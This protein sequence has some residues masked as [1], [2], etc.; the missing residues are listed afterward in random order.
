MTM[1]PIY[2]SR[3]QDQDFQKAFAEALEHPETS[4]LV[5][6]LSGMGGIGKTAL[7]KNLEETHK[8]D[9][10]FVKVSFD[11]NYG[12]DN[13]IKLMAALYDQVSD[14]LSVF[15][16]DIFAWHDPFS[17]LHEKY[18]AT[19]RRLKTEP[20][21]G[22]QSV[23]EG[24]LTKVKALLSM[25][26]GVVGQLIW[27]GIGGSTMK[28][29]TEAVVDGSVMVLTEK[30]RLE[31]LNQH[32]A[33]K[34]KKAVQD[35]MLEPLPKLTR[36]FVEG[37]IQWARRQP[38][39]LLLDTYEKVSTDIDTWLW[40]HL[41][42]NTDLQSH[43][44]RLVIA[45]RWP[46]WVREHW[47]KI[48]Q[49]RKI[50]YHQELI[51]FDQS[52]AKEY[53]KSIEKTPEQLQQIYDITKGWPYFLNWIREQGSSFDLSQGHQKFARFLLQGYSKEHQQFVYSLACCRTFDRKVAQFI[54]KHQGTDAQ[55]K[56]DTPLN[57]FEWLKQQSFV[58]FAEGAYRLDDV[59]RDVFRR[60][61]WQEDRE[62]FQQ[63]HA[64]LA[65]YFKE[66]ADQIVSSERPVLDGYNDPDWRQYMATY[67]Y[68]ALCS[69]Q[70]DALR[71]FI[72]H[73]FISSYVSQE[74]VV[75]KPFDSLLAEI[76]VADQPFLSE[77]LREFLT[78]I[79]PVV[80]YSIIF[81]LNVVHKKLRLL[82]QQFLEV[83]KFSDSEIQN[84]MQR[85]LRWIDS[86]E[87]LAKFVGLLYKSRHVLPIQQAEWCQKAYTQAEHIATTFTPEFGSRLFVEVGNEWWM[88]NQYA[89]AIAAYQKAIE[90]KPDA[91]EAWYNLGCV[92]ALQKDVKR[93]V[94][95]LGQAIQLDPE[96]RN[97]ACIDPDFDGIRDD[98]L[99]QSLLASE[100]QGSQ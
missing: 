41:I 28:K 83:I 92:Y 27:P 60:V 45:G 40:Y 64:Q 4:P 46:L 80:E 32:R 84:A 100:P 50:I 26:A 54:S 91:H 12:T 21:E 19:I 73:L 81:Q 38:I 76:S 56:T 87:G 44:I 57:W 55:P 2:I 71:N 3:K 74:D 5:F 68:H 90:I 15:Q 69:H 14:D 89:E 47:R 75:K 1:T 52:Q 35:L 93:A 13:P 61:L 58:K 72:A 18:N 16:K 39:V 99:F 43:P 59:A 8:K 42:A 36:A 7:L 97:Q 17:T 10:Q 65:G 25:S 6:N 22:K 20:V 77:T 62:H 51:R 82:Y 53:L 88:A 94:E 78:T 49:D 63:V 86:L 98:A 48:H 67:F 30:D 37:L 79:Q 23:D 95:F 33:T 24:Q 66:K 11:L 31:L 34:K 9:I 29:I 85:C 70:E 96:S